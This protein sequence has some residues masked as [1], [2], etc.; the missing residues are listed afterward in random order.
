M[1]FVWITCV[2]VCLFVRRVVGPQAAVSSFPRF[3]CVFCVCLWDDYLIWTQSNGRPDFNF[4]PPNWT[5]WA[6]DLPWVWT[7]PTLVFIVF[8]PGPRE[9]QHFT[10]CNKVP[11]KAP[12]LL[13]KK[14]LSVWMVNVSVFE[15][16]SDSVCS[17]FS[18]CPSLYFLYFLTQG[19]KIL[20]RLS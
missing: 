6:A 12:D 19:E 7:F 1:W 18:V 17:R 5:N 2:C 10:S 9:S 15:F 11:K 4:F 14:M 20:P 16:Q 8:P 13:G 3:P